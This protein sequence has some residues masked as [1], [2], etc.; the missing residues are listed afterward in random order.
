MKEAPFTLHLPSI[1]SILML[2]ANPS[3]LGPWPEHCLSADGALSHR[4]HRS[5]LLRLQGAFYEV[6]PRAWCQQLSRGNLVP[7]GFTVFKS[8]IKV[9]HDV[10]LWESPASAC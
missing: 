5:A 10:E 6:M 3:P 9:N 4:R 2:V 8:T 1:E 7:Q